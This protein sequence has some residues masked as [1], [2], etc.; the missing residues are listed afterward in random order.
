MQIRLATPTDAPAVARVHVRAWQVAYRGLLPDAHLDALR[1][2]ERAARYTFDDPDPRRPRTVVAVGDGAAGEILGFATTGPARDQAQVGR[3]EL[4]ALNVDPAH[5]NKGVG[6]AL[7]A[8]AREHLAR[9]G[10]R[11]A[12]LWVLDGNQRAYRFYAADGWAPDGSKRTE[13]VWGVRLTDLR[14]TRRLP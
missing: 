14:Y 7:I 5:W 10:Y 4:M 8:A 11:E 3:G 12:E 6:R 13:T 2:E 1:P 9:S